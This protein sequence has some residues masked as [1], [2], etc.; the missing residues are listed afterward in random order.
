MF[1][2]QPGR[3]NNV[4]CWFDKLDCCTKTKLL[5]SYCSSF[6]GCELWNLTCLDVQTFCVAWSQALRR[7]WKLSYNCDTA[8]LDRLSGSMCF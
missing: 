3:V 4:I 2:G 6:Y 8:I 1:I 5:G 7:I